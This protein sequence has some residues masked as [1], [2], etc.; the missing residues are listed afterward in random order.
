M[1]S[2]PILC[3]DFDGVIHSYTSKWRNATFIP[4]PPVPGALEFLIEACRFDGHFEVGIL[5][6]R[7]DTEAGREAMRT[8]LDH[9]LDVEFG[10]DKGSDVVMG[11]NGVRN[12]LKFYDKKPPAFVGIDDRV[13]TFNGKFPSL[14]RLKAFKPWNKQA[15]SEIFGDDPLDLAQFAG[16]VVDRHG[17]DVV[18]QFGSA[19]RE[20]LD[21]IFDHSLCGGR[22]DLPDV[23]PYED[24]IQQLAVAGYKIVPLGPNEMPSDP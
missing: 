19:V 23:V 13:L 21:Q 11:A 22:W 7:S 18:D 9:W 3:L 20:A 16:K 4:D 6:S 8:W 5:S 17:N 24:F 15:P 14:D 2:K 1:S 12:G 10:W